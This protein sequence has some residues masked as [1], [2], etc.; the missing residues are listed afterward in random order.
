MAVQAR[1]RSIISEAGEEHGTGF[2][3]K[4]RAVGQTALFAFHRLWNRG[5][6]IES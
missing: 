4:K 5:K 6:F 1:A 3:Q 2:L